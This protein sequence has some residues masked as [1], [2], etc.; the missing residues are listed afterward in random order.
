MGPDETCTASYRNPYHF[1]A[2]DAKS[3]K[4]AEEKKKRVAVPQPVLQ[5][6]ITRK[7]PG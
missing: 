3:A 7:Q 4:D 6:E 1:N 5:R 2:E